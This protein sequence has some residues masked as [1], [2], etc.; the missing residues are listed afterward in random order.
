MMN[1]ST[2][3]LPAGAAARLSNET[4]GMLLGLVGVLIF[5]L[6]LPFTRLAVAAFD[7]AFVALGRALVAAALAGAWLWWQ[8]APLPPRGALLPLAMVAGGCVVGFPWLT[9]IAMQTL[10]ASHGAVLVGILPLATALFSALRGNEKPSAGFWVTAV[11]GSALV[12]GFA[13]RQSGGA[14]HLADLAMFVAVVLGALGYAE[15]GRLSQSM[16][17]QQVISWAL[18]LSAPLLLP[19]VLWLSWSHGA[20]IAAAGAGAWLGFAYV[21]VFSMFIG[22]FFWYRGMALGGVARVGQTQLV[23]PFLT[24]LGAALLL[25]ETLEWSTVLFALA[26]IAVVAVGRKMQ[27]KR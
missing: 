25:G 12:V 24:L 27:I 2:L 26:V 15:G 14:F 1:N 13:L 18:V 10:P 9:S 23:Q 7:P 3:P 11:T 8:R 16:G 5:S 6:T 4:K 20:A 22:F 21:S 17:G 19:L